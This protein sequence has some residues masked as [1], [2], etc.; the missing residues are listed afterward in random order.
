[1]IAG[2]GAAKGQQAAPRAR[3]T[4]GAQ[5][6]EAIVDLLLH[7]LRHP[8]CACPCAQIL[9][10]DD[11]AEATAVLCPA[12]RLELHRGL[13]AGEPC[14]R[15]RKRRRANGARL[16]A[17]SE[18][19]SRRYAP[20]KS[21]LCLSPAVSAKT[22]STPGSCRRPPRRV[23][24]VRSSSDAWR[25]HQS[26]CVVPSVLRREWCMPGRRSRRR[27]EASAGKDAQE[28]AEEVE[29]GGAQGRRRRLGGGGRER[30]RLRRRGA[31]IFTSVC[32]Q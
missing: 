26:G 2:V 11:A 18:L 32:P 5:L 31:S 27:G 28:E 4:L 14:S 8:P 24:G 29:N 12:P 19:L 9:F 20:Y 16:L 10:Y 25:V 13:L 17:M 7:V 1:M 22:G 30:R 3:R 15:P 23:H 6:A 21:A